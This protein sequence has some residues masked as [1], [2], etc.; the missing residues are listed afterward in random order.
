[1]TKKVPQRANKKGKLQTRK[2][3][4]TD[5][6]SRYTDLERRQIGLVYMMKGSAK[7]TAEA[8]KADFPTLAHTTI[9]AWT[10]KEWWHEQQAALE[11]EYE[12]KIRGSLNSIIELAANEVQDRV[13][14]GD[15]VLNQKTGEV[16]RVP[17]KGKELMVVLG[18][19]FDKRRL[20]LNMPTAI[21]SNSGSKHLEELAKVFDKIA[22][23]SEYR[24]IR[25]KTSIPGELE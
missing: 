7:A 8:C 22:K 4:A 21:T 3:M 5:K 14:N 6:R 19:G 25:Q 18:V 23:E 24:T 2:Q 20:S 12:R 13:K 17:M 15:A 10:K 16:V 9:L 11:E 1:M